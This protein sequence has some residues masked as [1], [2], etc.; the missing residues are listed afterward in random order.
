M[1]NKQ[2]EISKIKNRLILTID[3]QKEID[4]N[5]F[6]KIIAN[7]VSNFTGID[8]ISILKSINDREKLKNTAFNC[9]LAFPH[10]ILNVHV[11]PKLIICKLKHNIKDWQCMDDTLVNTCLILLISKNAS[12]KNSSIKIMAS[13]YKKFADNDFLFQISQCSSAIEIKEKL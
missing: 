5:S 7:K 1:S 6:F 4:K 10:I 13:I 12:K 2:F 9:G 8:E 3:I 11:Q